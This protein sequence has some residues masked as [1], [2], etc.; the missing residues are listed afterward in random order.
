MQTCFPE[1]RLMTWTLHFLHPSALSRQ[2]Y[3]LTCSHS[4][5]YAF[6]LTH[7]HV[8]LTTNTGYTPNW[9]TTKT[10]S[11]FQLQ[12]I[13]HFKGQLPNHIYIYFSINLKT[14]L[15]LKWLTQLS[16]SVYSFLGK[17]SYRG[18][19]QF[20]PKALLILCLAV[21]L[22]ATPAETI[23]RTNNQLCVLWSKGI[24]YRL[25]LVNILDT[26][27]CQTQP[28]SCFDLLKLGMQCTTD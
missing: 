4:A 20:S 14:F 23:K 7:W 9:R 17:R 8:R 11:E 16:I 3:W 12:N 13:S 25:S 19:N 1:A 6:T 27:F 22:L 5:E 21:F 28:L 10:W 2:P 15:S 18:C 24:L 26:L